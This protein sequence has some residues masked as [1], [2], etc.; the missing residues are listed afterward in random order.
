MHLKYKLPQ[1][2]LLWW[3]YKQPKHILTVA[4]RFVRLINNQISFTLNIRLIFTPLF[5]DYTIVGHVIG[6]FIRVFQIIFGLIFMLVLSIGCL[7]LPLAWYAI[8]YLIFKLEGLP[9][10]FAAVVLTY[11]YWILINLN[12]PIFSV[13]KA[14]KINAPLAMKP[15]VYSIIQN[16]SLDKRQT[17]SELLENKNIQKLLIKSELLSMEFAQKIKDAPLSQVTDLLNRAFEYA[18]SQK[19]KYVEIEQVFLAILAGIPK[20]E[21]LLA[22]YGSK[23]AYVEET[24]KWIILDREASNKIYIWQEDY[25]MMLTGGIGRGMTGRVTP[26]LDSVSWDFT[27]EVQRGKIRSI[28]GRENEIK[29]IAEILSKAGKNNVLIVGPP[30]SGKTSIVKGIA[31]KVIDG[32]EHKSLENKRIVSLEI[33]RLIS[34]AKT[35]GQI[36]ERL[37]RV[38]DDVIGS[39]DIILFVDEIHNLVAGGGDTE[40]EVSTIYSS[41]EPYLASNQIQFIG[42]TSIPNY[43]KYIEPNGAFARLFDVI[44]IDQATKE[45][46]IEILKEKAE[47][48]SIKNK[49]EVTY[50]A[51]LKIVELSD[52][53]IHERVLPDKAIDILTRCSSKAASLNK[54]VSSEDVAQEISEITHVPVTA[55]SQD[56]AQ[57]LLT[58]EDNI[59][60]MVIGQDEA[61]RQVSAA[62]KR[63]RAGIR[64]ENRPIASF[65]FVG[66]TGVGKTQTAKALAKTYFGDAKNMI[67]LDMSEYQQLDS[68]ERIIGAPNGST[69][70]ILTEHVRTRPFALILLDEI[71]KAHAN[72][73]LT[74]L[75]VLDD[76][77]L[78]DSSGIVV[79]FTNT[80]IIATSN[81]GTRSIQ[82]IFAES[83]GFDQMKETAMRDVRERFAPEFLNRFS[84]IIVFNPLTRD[85][86]R[87]IA[88]LL[89]EDVRKNAEAKGIKLKFREE[90][91]DKLIEKGYNPE[92]GA[93][94]LARVIEDTIETYLATAILSQQ[95]QQGSEVLIGNE[96]FQQQ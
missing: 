72:I 59:K 10:L 47:E 90:I 89:L 91:L 6:F 49:I 28:V 26:S 13:K 57:K 77:R 32:T 58:I 51:L 15:S 73:L 27:K 65:L 79:D 61:V 20:I 74:F 39:G 56:E 88:Q 75:Q 71:E 87:K 83:G 52:R 84:G 60:T 38:M 86:V 54:L 36:S 37:N 30:G 22:T 66:T 93:R 34:G 76:G 94:P 44:E 62:L 40:A 78:T 82:Q 31:Y 8:P 14:T 42:A 11:L 67:R 29:K 53:L 17:L 55:I 85:S 19:T 18:T 12:S 3:A 16:F 63:A 1:F 2:F 5:G 25:Q 45:D 7:M 96:I 70:G 4:N 92:W 33:S 68:I 48:L 9:Y 23:L 41:L 21:I 64:N 24:V 81:V 80:I 46:T 43:R 50:P 69:K 95:L 35:A